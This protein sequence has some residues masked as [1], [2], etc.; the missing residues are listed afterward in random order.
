[1]MERL[2][3]QLSGYELENNFGVEDF[4]LGRNNLR[5]YQVLVDLKVMR[6]VVRAHVKPVWHHAYTQVGSSDSVVP[7][8]LAHEVVSQ[9]FERMVARATVKT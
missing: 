5:A 6:I 9:F 3:F 8:A 1:M 4:L 2:P 7:V